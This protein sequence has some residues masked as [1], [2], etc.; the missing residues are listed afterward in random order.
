MSERS[1]D[2]AA[3][4]FMIA[5]LDLGDDG[6]NVPEQAVDLAGEEIGHRLGRAPIGH[7]LELDAGGRLEELKPEVGDGAEP[8]MLMVMAPGS[9]ASAASSRAELTG[10]DAFTT[11]MVELNTAMPTGAKSLI[12]S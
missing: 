7:G 6:R 3:S 10:I 9:A 2:V 1:C 5:R 8:M 4:A 11:S 12:G